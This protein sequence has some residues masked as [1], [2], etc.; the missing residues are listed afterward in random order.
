MTTPPRAIVPVDAPEKS[1][2]DINHLLI[3]LQV[4]INEINEA[5]TVIGQ[6]LASGGL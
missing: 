4:V 1:Y 5:F 6:R 3:W 2:D